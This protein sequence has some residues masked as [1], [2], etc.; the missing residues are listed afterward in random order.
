MY[1]NLTIDDCSYRALHYMWECYYCG[2][3]KEASESKYILDKGEPV[4]VKFTKS[5]KLFV[6]PL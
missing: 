3:K 4:K 6:K 2:T 1:P 5:K